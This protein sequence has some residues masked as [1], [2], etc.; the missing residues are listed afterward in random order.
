M[1]KLVYGLI[2][3][4]IV[5]VAAALI[6]PSMIDWNSYKAEIIAQAEQATG[7][8]LSI[9]GD[10]DLAVLPSPRLSAADVR[11]ANMAG[12]GEPEMARLKS[13]SV[14]VRLAPLLSGKIEVESVALIEPVIVLERLANGRANWEFGEP[15]PSGDSIP[16][17]QRRRD[18]AP[19]RPSS[20]AGPTGL[21]LDSLR[22]VDGT[23]VY[24][25]AA[26]QTEE[27]VEKLNVELSAGSIHGPFE[28][29]GKL[30]ARGIPLTVAASV[31]ELTPTSPASVKL[32]LGFPSAGAEA[33]FTGGLSDAETA[34]RLAGKLSA[35]GN[36]LA[37]LLG[38]ISGGGHAG[39]EAMPPLDQ[40]F[41]LTSQLTGTAK[42]VALDSVAIRLGETSVSGGINAV[43]GDKIQADIA[44]KVGHV[45]LDKYLAAMST[46][47]TPASAGKSDADPEQSAAP[48]AAFTLP[49]NINGSLDLA[50]EALTLRGGQIRG[51]KFEASLNEGELTLNQMTARLPGGAQAS[52]FGFLTAH[53]GKP[54]FDGTV[55]IRADN[56]RAALQWLQVDVA[57]VPADRLRKFV[58]T[59]KLRGGASQVQVAGINMQLDASRAKGGLTY[60]LGR[61]RP[62]FGARFSV[63]Q[64]NLDAYMP[65][66][67]RAPEKAATAAAAVPPPAK[68]ADAGRGPLAMLQDFDANFNLRVG[69]LNF[70]RTPIQGVALNGTLQRGVL[71]LRN[72]KIRNLARTTATLKGTVSGFA[73]LPVFKGR[74]SAA[75]KDIT[76]LLRVAGI[77]TKLPARQLGRLKLTGRA[78]AAA[79]RVRLDTSLEL[80]GGKVALAGDLVGLPQAPRFDLKIDASHPDFTRLAR[81]FGA[82]PQGRKKGYGPFGLG[83]RI[84]GD[85]RSVD[86]DT[87]VKILGGEIKIVGKVDDP[88]G[89]PAV[90]GKIE[91][92]HRSFVKLM[93]A[94]DPAFRPARRV[95][96][97]V[98]LA[99][100]VL[101]NATA[102]RLE[103]L[104]ASAAS[105]NVT[106][107]GDLNFSG[108]RPKL[109]AALTAGEINLNNFVSADAGAGAG[110]ASGPGAAIAAPAGA[111]RAATPKAR[112]P[113][114]FSRVP[115]DLSVL[116]AL[117][118]DV[119]TDARAIL[120]KNFRVD[121]PQVA[122][123]I[124]DRVLTISRLAGKMFGGGFDMTGRLDGAAVP[125]LDG[126]V[127]IERANVGEALFK[128]A[129]FDIANGALSFD[130]AVAAK[131]RSEF[132]LISALNGD[133]RMNVRNGAVT[134]FDLRA[135]SNRLKRLNQATDFLGLFGAA[136]GGGTTRFSSLDGTFQIRK[137]VLRTKD[138]KLVA[139]AGEGNATGFADLPRWNMDFISQFRLTEHPKAPPFGMRVVGPV[140]QPRRLFKFEKMQAFLL[141]RGIGSLLNRALTGRRSQPRPAPSQPP[142]DQQA[143]PQPQP[144]Q[145]PKPKEILR[146]LLEGLIRR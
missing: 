15:S 59:A 18:D 81:V 51:V 110:R 82:G 144:Q 54:N 143:Q 14:R 105:V 33:E 40:A 114:R 117:D 26:T 11:F 55:E 13:L 85:L 87:T 4:V 71:T 70:R 113:G 119:K 137:G 132:E 27:R 126:K 39:G 49:A 22:I 116:D 43:I 125:A 106:G 2:G 78:D 35:K 121:Q 38:T 20:A 48:T 67:R 84:K 102:V 72:A 77:K 60:A 32:A 140:D 107:G 7:R 86:L 100:R 95:T 68:A 58:F 146:G 120:W 65:S 64:F 42:S 88:A 45:D 73:G 98:S 118:A 96:G 109:T 108:K 91:A 123:A 94:L 63:D 139:E 76:G 41:T 50:V 66:P 75:S 12:A 23:L 61:V 19:S 92:R 142:P 138:M 62:A 128:A 6:V 74:F 1:R 57:A 36:S 129:N 17:A 56:L 122:L 141:Q 8:K 79:D 135:V 89:T 134:G 127:R 90:D 29:D 133:G 69:T 124:Q 31:D 145:Q 103:G 80:A 130:M 46:A 30:A 99:T 3:L 115:L 101:G 47:K 111:V 25:D 37:A 10:L 136:M 34:P 131:G 24:R 44:L 93:R 16:P 28:I 83:G 9:N 52:L 97:G 5:L 112:G 53:R 21:R 104:R